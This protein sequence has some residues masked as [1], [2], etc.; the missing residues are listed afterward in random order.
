[1]AVVGH[2]QSQVSIKISPKGGGFTQRVERGSFPGKGIGKESGG[3]LKMV[4]LVDG[5]LKKGGGS[6]LF[7]R[8]GV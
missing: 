3:G 5:I 8:N 4:K 2:D 7:I 1:M 6:W